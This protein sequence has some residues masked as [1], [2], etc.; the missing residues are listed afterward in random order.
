EANQ[1]NNGY[2]LAGLA[3]DRQGVVVVPAHCLEKSLDAVV[4]VEEEENHRRNVNGCGSS[5]LEA[6][7]HHGVNI[8]CGSRGKRGKPG[9]YVRRNSS[10]EVK[11]VTD[12]EYPQQ[13]SRPYHVSAGKGCLE[14]SVHRITG[15]IGSLVFQGNL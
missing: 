8:E 4:Q 10:G 13:H 3:D 9:G 15:G 1:K 6:S 12:D 5:V 2:Y 7:D 11:E 14:L